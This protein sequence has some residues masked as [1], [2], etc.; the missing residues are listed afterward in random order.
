[1]GGP[2]FVGSDN[3]LYSRTDGLTAWQ[4]TGEITDEGQRCVNSKTNRLISG[5]NQMNICSVKFKIPKSQTLTYRIVT[6]LFLFVSG[7]RLALA[8]LLSG[9]Q[10]VRL[11]V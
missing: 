11:L 5:T 1:M 4:A 6:L 2:D 8:R 3:H 10:A 7:A 9:K